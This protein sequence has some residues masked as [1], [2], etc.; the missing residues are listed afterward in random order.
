MKISKINK[1]LTIEGS[2]FCCKFEVP[3]N[4]IYMTNVQ[5]LSK[6]IW[7]SVKGFGGKYEISSLGNLR[8]TFG[9]KR[10]GQLLKL[11]L[12][13]S[14]YLFLPLRYR[15]ESKSAFIPNPRDLPVVNHRNGIKT[16]NRLENL[17]WCSHEH[18]IRHSVLSGNLKFEHGENHMNSVL[19]DDA[20]RDIRA[21]YKPRVYSCQKL[22][23]KY[24]V[25]RKTVD[26]VVKFKTWAHVK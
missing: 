16:D 8:T 18:N 15:E 21:S 19:N 2:R 6:E 25:N 13:N 9:Y 20:V 26:A 7:R 3:L 10:N 1:R 14:G 23:D 24:G 5:N 12:S 17:E 4:Q 22:A 11:S